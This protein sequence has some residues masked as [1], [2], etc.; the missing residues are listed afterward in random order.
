MVVLTYCGSFAFVVIYF[1][2]SRINGFSGFYIDFSFT[3][4]GSDNIIGII[5]MFENILMLS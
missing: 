4:L 2:G 3:L 1:P 5:S